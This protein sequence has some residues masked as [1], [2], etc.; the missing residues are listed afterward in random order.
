MRRSIFA[1]VAA[2]VFVV[3]V[4]AQ[5][6]LSLWPYYIEV[7]PN[8][9]SPDLYELI[10]PRE[11]MDRARADLADLRLFDGANREVPYAIRIRRDVNERRQ[12]DA[13]LFNHAVAGAVSEVSVDLGENPGEHNEVEIDTGG[14][15][16]RR[17]VEVQGSD[18]G[19]EWRT[20]TSEGMLFSFSAQNSA[21]ESTRVQYPASRYRYLRLRVQR[22]PVADK[23]APRISGVRVGMAVREQGVFSTW[24]VQVPSYQLLRN[25][26]AHATVWTID[27]GVRVPCDRL[28]LYFEE[29]SF[30]RPFQV[31]SIDDPQNV[32]LLATGELRRHVGDDSKRPLE[33]TFYQEQVVRK[34]RLQ[35]TDYSNPTLNLL[36]IEASAPARQLLFELKGPP[37]QPLRLFFGNS[38][39]EAPHYDF[40]K[41]LPTMRIS[42][43]PVQSSFSEVLPNRE[44]QPEPLPLTERAPWLIYIVL[45]A[46]S[47]ALGFVLFSLART[48]MRPGTQPSSE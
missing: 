9:S 22:D 10:L 29:P 37:S 34:I 35:I 2:L 4:Y 15:N 36:S 11:V 24:H 41:Q 21:A 14:S 47:I 12:I 28:K 27:L 31:E 39:V 8:Q 32:R 19:S 45:A 48:A 33:I 5:T 26:G 38:K 40:E 30:S 3:S 6:S 25:Q 7:R 18:S 20:L 1:I 44:Y 46:S 16:F 17:Q 42:A 43:T 23:D 13:R